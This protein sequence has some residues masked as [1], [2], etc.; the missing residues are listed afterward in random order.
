MVASARRHRYLLVLALASAIL[1]PLLIG[2]MMQ[3]AES[4]AP[5]PSFTVSAHAAVTAS[6][7]LTA[8]AA[9]AL[10]LPDA[11]STATAACLPGAVAHPVSPRSPHPCECDH[12]CAAWALPAWSQRGKYLVILGL[13]ALSALGLFGA[14]IR[15]SVSNRQPAGYRLPSMW[16]ADLLISLGVAR[17]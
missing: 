6:A 7:A 1:V 14:A 15:R 9:A 2:R 8:H 11:A 4:P 13:I 10:G 5:A 16:D 3:P 17:T 12:A